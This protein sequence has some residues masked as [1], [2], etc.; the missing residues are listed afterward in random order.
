MILHLLI[1]KLYLSFFIFFKNFGSFQLKILSLLNNFL[2][3]SPIPYIKTKSFFFS[4][5]DFLKSNHSDCSF[6]E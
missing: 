1:P 3:F 6:E 4:N 2:V 5:I